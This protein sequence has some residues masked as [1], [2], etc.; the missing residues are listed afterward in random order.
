MIILLV[1]K[2]IDF[3]KKKKKKQKRGQLT[4]LLKGFSSLQEASV[5]LQYKAYHGRKHV[6]IR[7]RKLR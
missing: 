1:T 4:A 3:L 2:T 7:K 5:V 6:P